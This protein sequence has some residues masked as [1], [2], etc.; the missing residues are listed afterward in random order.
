[1]EEAQ[2]FRVSASKKLPAPPCVVA[3]MPAVS[4]MRREPL[5]QPSPANRPFR[6][7]RS[8][9]LPAVSSMRRKPLP[10]PPFAS[11][12]MPPNLV[13]YRCPRSSSMSVMRGCSSVGS[14]FNGPRSAVVPLCGSPVNAPRSAVPLCREASPLMPL[15][16]R[17]A[18]DRRGKR[19]GRGLPV[20]ATLHGPAVQFFLKIA[21]PADVW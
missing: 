5:P 17:F 7:I 6:F 12:S 13:R 8:F 15:Q 1:M 18:G 19:G 3:A 20:P 9:T 16:N 21:F 4:S 11:S 14:P 2:P 10:Q